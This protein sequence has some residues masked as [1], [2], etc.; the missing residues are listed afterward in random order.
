MTKETQKLLRATI[1]KETGRC[2]CD[3]C[4]KLAFRIEGKAVL[5]S[6]EGKAICDDCGGDSGRRVLALLE[7][8]QDNPSATTMLLHPGQNRGRMSETKTNQ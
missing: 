4:G 7:S 2:T 8:A 6:S 5:F 1:Q 3:L